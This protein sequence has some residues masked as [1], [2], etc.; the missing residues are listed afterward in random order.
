MLRKDGSV[1][2]SLRNFVG[3]RIIKFVV[4]EKKYQF[5]LPQGPMLN[6]LCCDNNFGFQIQNENNLYTRSRDNL[7]KTKFAEHRTTAYLSSKHKPS[8]TVTLLQ[9]GKKS[10][11]RVEK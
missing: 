9:P 8:Q 2:I 10:L 11:N 6:F 7:S 5:I 1:T 4:S 3:E